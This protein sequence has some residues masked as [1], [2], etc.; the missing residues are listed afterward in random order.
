MTM[1][2]GLGAQP[3]LCRSGSTPAQS[4]LT[5]APLHSVSP[6]QAPERAGEAFAEHAVGITPA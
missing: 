5:A 1:T 3:L 6:P 4:S 2:A